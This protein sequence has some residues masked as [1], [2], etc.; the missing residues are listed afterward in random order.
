MEQILPFHN[1]VKGKLNLAPHVWDWIKKNQQNPVVN[2]FAM[3]FIAQ[4]ALFDKSKFFML[5]DTA[6]RIKNEIRKQADE[7]SFARDATL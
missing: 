1:L 5:E 3:F 7:E 6:R 4:C 2:E